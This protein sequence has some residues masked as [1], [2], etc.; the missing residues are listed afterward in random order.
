MIILRDNGVLNSRLESLGV[1]SD[2]IPMLNTDFAVIL[3]MTYGFLP[4]AILPLYVSID[5]MDQNLVQAAATCTRTVEPR[6]CT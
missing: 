4:F 2:P 1:I 3:G 6:S 5:R